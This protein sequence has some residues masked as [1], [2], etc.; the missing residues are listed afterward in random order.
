[1]S[2]LDIFKG[3][4][5]VNG[6][7]FKSLMETTRRMAGGGGGGRR[8]SI[9]GSKFRLMEGGNQVSVSKSDTMNLVVLDAAPVART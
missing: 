4:A 3:N 9:R 7:L 6:D 5:L 1:M 2:T 8:I